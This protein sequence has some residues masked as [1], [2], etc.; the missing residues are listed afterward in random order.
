MVAISSSLTFRR[1]ST[2]LRC[3]SSSWAR[4]SASVMLLKAVAKSP[5]KSTRCEKSP[6]A[7]RSACQVRWRRCDC[8][9]LR[10][11]AMTPRGFRAAERSP[12]ASD[13]TNPHRLRRSASSWASSAGASAG[14][15]TGRQVRMVSRTTA[16]A[17]AAGSRVGG[18]VV[19]AP[20]LSIGGLAAAAVAA[21][22]S[23]GPQRHDHVVVPVCRVL[24]VCHPVPPRSRVPG[25]VAAGVES[26][27]FVRGASRQVLSS[28][29]ESHVTQ[30]RPRSGTCGR[31]CTSS[32]PPSP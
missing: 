26:S 14:R 29:Y 19:P 23:A 17:S 22:S 16:T 20:V 15:S 8:R 21:L 5:M 6:A 32:R 4:A 3:E 12:S 2:S 24:L 31:R 10:V 13:L 1:T 27:A 11:P 28:S 7:T 9:S 18:A 25:L 30:P